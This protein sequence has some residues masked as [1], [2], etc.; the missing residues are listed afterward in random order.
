MQSISGIP[1]KL[2]KNTH[3]VAPAEVN[4]AAGRIGTA[5]RSFTIGLFVLFEF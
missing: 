1:K 5:G 3:T 4:W 2:I